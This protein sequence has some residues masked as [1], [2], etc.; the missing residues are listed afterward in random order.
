MLPWCLPP[1]QPVILV[2]PPTF[3]MVLLMVD[4]SNGIIFWTKGRYKASAAVP[5]LFGTN[6]LTNVRIC[7]NIMYSKSTVTMLRPYK[8]KNK[9]QLLVSPAIF[10]ASLV[11]F[12]Q[13]IARD[14]PICMRTRYFPF[15]AVSYWI[16]EEP[17]SNFHFTTHFWNYFLTLSSVHVVNFRSC[18]Q[19]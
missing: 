7:R 13:L 19:M 17:C 8:R 11:Q 6:G 15:C 5:L 4:R 10:I 18:V 12:H 16:F 1:R 9:E 3:P 2:V 14:V